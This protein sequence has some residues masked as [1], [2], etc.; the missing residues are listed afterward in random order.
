VRP[1]VGPRSVVI[2][3]MR[4]SKPLGAGEEEGGVVAVEVEMEAEVWREGEGEEGEEEREVG[5]EGMPALRLGTSRARAGAI[6]GDLVR[7]LECAVGRGERGE[8]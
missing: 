7:F 2:E 3:A 5:L 4:A 8:M 1:E 6:V